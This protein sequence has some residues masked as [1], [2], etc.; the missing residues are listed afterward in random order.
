MTPP[1]GAAGEALTIG[2]AALRQLHLSLLRDAGDGAITILQETG[3]AAGEGVYQA[4]CAWLPAQGIQRPEDIEAVR[5]GEV[6]S[7]FF[8]DHG[9]GSLSVAPVG[10]AAV[11]LDSTD[12]VEAEP[13][14]AEGPMCYF[15]SGMLADF[16]GRL[17]G[18]PVSVLE[19]ECRSRN[20]GRC[21][22]LSASPDTLNTVYEQLTQGR[23]YVEALGA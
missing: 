1:P 13:G 2:R 21:R 9:W 5:L 15:S 10:P 8:Q 19:V 17:S 18:A 4:F 12:W 23:S 20:D 7:R 6:L 16:L 3:Y 14:T 11:A 22:F